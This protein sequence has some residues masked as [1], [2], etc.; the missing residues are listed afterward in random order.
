MSEE[1]QPERRI[2]SCVCLM[3]SGISQMVKTQYEQVRVEERAG[4]EKR[5]N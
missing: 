5:D 1:G 2:S 4:I 3:E